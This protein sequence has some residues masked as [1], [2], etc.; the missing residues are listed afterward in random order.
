MTAEN[1]RSFSR[2]NTRLRAYMRKLVTPETALPLF[3]SAQTSLPQ[4]TGKQLREANIPVLLQQYL[5]G[6]NEK[7][8]TL[9]NLVTRD[10]LREDFPLKTEVVELSG[11]G[12]KCSPPEREQLEVGDMIEVV[13]FLSQNPLNMA[14]AVCTLLRKEDST[15]PVLVLEFTK[16]RESERESIVQFVFSEQREQI[17]ES[18]H[19]D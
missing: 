19:G 6:L 17:R 5:E 10:L 13:I 11:A 18:K 2:I 16:I 12:L 9:I 1:N 7:L 15:Q 8:D 3:H 14:S 4:P